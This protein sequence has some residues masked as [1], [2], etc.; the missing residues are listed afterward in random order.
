LETRKPE[1]K[2]SGSTS[3]PFLVFWILNSIL[4]FFSAE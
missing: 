4:L 2:T 3:F 1:R